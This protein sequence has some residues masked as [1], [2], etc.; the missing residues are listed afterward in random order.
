M[1]QDKLYI[2]HILDAISI[3]EEYIQ[4]FDFKMFL[5]N[6]EILAISLELLFKDLTGFLGR[7]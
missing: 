1:E 5:K 4:N 7:V 2:R 3:I 6:K